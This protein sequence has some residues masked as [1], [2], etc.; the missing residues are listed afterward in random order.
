[1]ASLLSLL[2]AGVLIGVGQ[3]PAKADVTA[4]SGSAFGYYSSVAF[5]FGRGP[6]PAEVDGP[7]PTV[8]LPSTGGSETASVESGS[9]AAGPAVFF[10]SGP[11]TVRTE[12]ATGPT[13]SST[14]SVSIT[15]T[16]DGPDP[17][18]YQEVSS[19][20]TSTETSTTASTTLTGASINLGGGQSVVVPDNPAPNTEY[21][22]T[23]DGVDDRFRIVINEQIVTSDSITVN[24]MHMYLLGPIALGEVIVGQA[25]CDV[26]ATSSNEAPVAGDDEFAMDANTRL[27]VPAPGVL[28]NDVAPDGDLLTAQMNSGPLSSFPA[29]GSLTLN[30]D[31]SFTYIPNTGFSGTDSFTYLVRDPRGGSDTATVTITV[32]PPTGGGLQNDNFADAQVISGSSGFITTPDNV[33]ATTEPGE[34]YFEGGRSIWY[35]WTA[36]VG[37]YATF[38]TCGTNYS[39]ALGVYTGESL[40][41]LTE[42]AG[43]PY[44]N[45][46]CPDG[47]PAAQVTFQVTAG[48]TYHIAVASGQQNAWGTTPLT[49]NVVPSPPNDDFAD[50][51]VI[52]GPSGSVTG[53]NQ[54]S[55][56]EGGELADNSIWYR[57]T[58]PADGVFAFDTCGSDFDGFLAIYTGES[59]GT[60]TDVRPQHIHGSYPVPECA[61]PRSRVVFRATAGTA[62][63]VLVGGGSTGSVV[64]SWAQLPHAP[65]DDFADAEVI[66]GPSGSVTGSNAPGSV[67]TVEP[68]ESYYHANGE[69]EVSIW[70]RWTAPADGEVTFE[71]CDSTFNTLLAVY[72]GDAVDALTEL[73]SNDDGCESGGG[74]RVTFVATAGTVYQIAVDG[75]GA[76]NGT[77]VLEWAQATPPNQAPLAVDDP[78]RTTAGRVLTVTAPGVL[79][80]DTDPD[81]DAM[82]AGSASDPAGGSV[83]LNGDG[84]FAYT[85][86][87]GFTGTDT[88]TYTVSDGNGGTATA[89]VTI[90][91]TNPVTGPTSADACKN[92]GWKTFS[93]PTFKNQGECASYVQSNPKASR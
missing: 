7:A 82:T 6:G 77:V 47:S 48:T 35:Q 29:N 44:L 67:A 60:L 34:P 13:G 86:D 80:N 30:P 11:I 64:L 81:G 40:D 42:V 25:H 43:T 93:N 69:A 46:E 87:T 72:T 24:A 1:M 89:T 51:E 66:S 22:G 23:I 12:G 26:V 84:S 91:V 18:H 52:S 65:N 63:H 20:C 4:A 79:A 8:T 78:Y 58:A 49:W 14:S 27:N 68:G 33:D 5:D 92:G 71:T 85:P 21:F 59:I 56:S 73:A 70:Y 19:T 28:A 62:Y 37:G 3:A 74:S 17:F 83:V 38:D 54:A 45:F 75:F 10:E 32:A 76:E 36:P 55:T 61:G 50:A 41:A 15:G 53:T 57:W 2:S 39:T 90:T 31:G 16:P 9:A 88:F